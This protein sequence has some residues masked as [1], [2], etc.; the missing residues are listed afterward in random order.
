MTA[1]LHKPG[2]GLAC[3]VQEDRAMR[4]SCA[5]ATIIALLS[6]AAAS[7]DPVSA[8]SPQKAPRA[9]S[10]GKELKDLGARRIGPGYK[11]SWSRDGT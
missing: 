10:I 8:Q 6:F 5:K 11:P 3:G 9:S 4:A 2:D 7:T 1:V